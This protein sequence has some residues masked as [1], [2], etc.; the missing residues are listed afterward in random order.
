M[1]KA[2]HL[3]LSTQVGLTEHLFL[4]FGRGDEAVNAL[5]HKPIAILADEV[6]CTADKVVFGKWMSV[7]GRKTSQRRQ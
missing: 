1:A 2:E 3:N 7:L 6:A 4:L 5:E